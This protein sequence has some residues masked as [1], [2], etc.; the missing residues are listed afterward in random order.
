MNNQRMWKFV[1]VSL[2]VYSVI[3]TGVAYVFF[4]ENLE[5]L[6]SPVNGD[7]D[8]ITVI[9]IIEY[10]AQNS[11]DS[12]VFTKTIPVNTTMYD[13]LN[14]TVQL[15]GQWFPPFGF[16]VSGINNV[17]EDLSKGIF[18]FFYYWD[19][20][21]EKWISSPIGVTHFVLSQLSIVKMAYHNSTGTF[22]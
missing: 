22:P 11:T 13:L 3:I 12:T 10:S 8:E 7:L 17:S 4:N 5:S 15:T 1:I 9:L 16:Y 19:Y 20:N 14:Q 21:A 18:W 2:L 6:S